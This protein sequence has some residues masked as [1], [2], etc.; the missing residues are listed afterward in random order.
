LRQFKNHNRYEKNEQYFENFSFENVI[1]NFF[2]IFVFCFYRIAKY[3]LIPNHKEPLNHIVIDYFI[4]FC[5]L[6]SCLLLKFWLAGLVVFS[7]ILIPLM[8]G[9]LI[10]SLRE[11]RSKTHSLKEPMPTS[12]QKL[13]TKIDKEYLAPDFTNMSDDEV[14]K[15]VGYIPKPRYSSPIKQ[16]PTV[17]QVAETLPDFDGMDEESIIE[18]VKN[19]PGLVSAK[20]SK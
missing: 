18:F 10:K 2:V 7:L 4:T 20:G 15:R 3:N 17:K 5:I 6:L 16:K 13:Q 19:N 12:G 11:E 9:K 1:K 8:V 14:L